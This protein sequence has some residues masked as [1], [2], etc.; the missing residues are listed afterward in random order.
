[1]TCRVFNANGNQAIRVFSDNVNYDPC[2]PSEYNGARHAVKNQIILGITSSTVEQTNML[3]QGWNWF[4]ANVEVTL[5]DLKAALVEALPSTSITIKSNSNGQAMYNGFIWVG[6][7]SSLDVTQMYKIS[8]NT[9][10]EI[11]LEGI[12]V[13]P[14]DHPVTITNGTNWIGFPLGESMAVANAFAGFPINGDFVKSKSDGQAS[15]NGRMWVGGLLNLAPGN[16]Y[17]Y[18]SNA[19]EDRTLIFPTGTK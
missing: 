18:I 15:W 7:L 4:S 8:V 5:N 16:G 17:I 13:N 14:V 1:M 11:S 3:V 19:A 10:C 9:D 2:N 6:A 12:P